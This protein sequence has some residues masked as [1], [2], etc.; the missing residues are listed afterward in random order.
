MPKIKIPR[1]STSIDM[2][3]MCD[4]SFLLL[5]FFMLTTQ[6]KADNQVIVDTPSS[7][8]EI[9]LPDTDIMNISITKDGKVFF[10]ID[11]KNFTRERLLARI[12]EK[13]PQIKLNA[14]A[15][16]AFVLNGVVGVPLTEF[17]GYY[18]LQDE[19]RKAYQMKGIPVDSTNNELGDW[20]MQG[21][22][23]NPGV[24]ITVNGDQGCP[25][26][27]VKKVMNTLQDKNVNKF[28]LI[29]DLEADPNKL[30]GL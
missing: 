23:S 9:K 17:K 10:A 2:T 14:E 8:S 1:K 30:K 25:W 15:Q 26:P 13:F 28:N 21:R 5:T 16:K 4:V 7:I 24:R 6:F 19:D 20:I 29:T 18:E 12:E 11:N 22:L 3:A 27:V